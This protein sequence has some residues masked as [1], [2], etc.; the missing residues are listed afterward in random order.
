MLTYETEIM[1]IATRIWK[2]VLGLSLAPCPE[3]NVL[4]DQKDVFAGCIQFSQAWKGA[5]V[6]FCSAGLAHRAASAIFNTEAEAVTQDQAADTIIELTNI[7]GGNVKSLLPKP[8]VLS[9]PLV[10]MGDRL[11]FTVPGGKMISQ[12]DLESKGDAMK[13]LLMQQR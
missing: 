5:L 7:T 4:H 13:I 10:V 3:S 9:I 12:V 11:N 2:T 1:E 6:L 8:C